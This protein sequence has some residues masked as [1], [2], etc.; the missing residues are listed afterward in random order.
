[1]PAHGQNILVGATQSLRAPRRLVFLGDSITD[2][3]TLILHVEQALAALGDPAIC[4]N[5]GVSG[6][7]ADQMLAR[8]D[9]DVRPCRPTVVLICRDQ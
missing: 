2:G 3:H 4:Y 1:M 9:Q 8:L 6:D 7:R 5:A